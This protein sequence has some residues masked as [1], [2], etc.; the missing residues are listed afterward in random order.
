MQNST[1]DHQE[2]TMPASSMPGQNFL[3][4]CV[5]SIRC[6]GVGRRHLQR[7]FHLAN[8]ISEAALDFRNRVA[9]SEM[10]RLVKMLEIGTQFFKKFLGKAVTHRNPIVAMFVQSCK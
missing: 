7:R 2:E 6:G 4:C 10:T 3:A 1:T 9:L 5:F 8:P